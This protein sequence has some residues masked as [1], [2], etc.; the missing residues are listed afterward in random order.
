MIVLGVA[1]RA[2]CVSFAPL[3]PHCVR[4]T[5]AGSML[6]ALLAPFHVLSSAASCDLLAERKAAKI[7]FRKSKSA[8]TAP[9]DSLTLN[10]A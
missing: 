7:R 8:K 3:S 9:D 10:V 4:R 5:C 1:P 6:L 2:L